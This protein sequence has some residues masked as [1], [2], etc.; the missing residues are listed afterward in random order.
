M[1]LK[2]IKPTTLS[3]CEKQPTTEKML[4]QKSPIWRRTPLWV[5]VTSEAS[6]IYIWSSGP[7]KGHTGCLLGKGPCYFS[8]LYKEST[9]YSHRT[10]TGYWERKQ[11]LLRETVTTVFLEVSIASSSGKEL[12]SHLERAHEGFIHTHHGACIVKLATV[13]GC[14]KQSD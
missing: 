14:R 7:A 11:C 6:L 3:N 1:T 12:L 13:V 2:C 5:S 9:H 8:F 10:N 4:W